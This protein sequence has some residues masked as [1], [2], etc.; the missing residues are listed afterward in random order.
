M[1][2][3]RASATRTAWEHKKERDYNNAVG[4]VHVTSYLRRSKALIWR[5]ISF[6]K[7][8][9]TDH[10]SR[11][12]LLVMFQMRL[13]KY[14]SMS[15]NFKNYPSINGNRAIE[16]TEFFH[17]DM[18]VRILLHH[19]YIRPSSSEP[20]DFINW[21][22]IRTRPKN[23]QSVSRYVNR[24][25]TSRVIAIFRNL[26]AQKLRNRFNK[27]HPTSPNRLARLDQGKKNAQVCQK[28]QSNVRIIS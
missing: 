28:S 20:H 17:P 14:L 3:N 21:T 9:W 27:T 15:S 25:F 2:L 7:V 22:G 8:K 26:T 5:K 10:C 6:W 19:D 4:R 18:Y 23:H 16:S 1:A 13:K 12:C 11:I 24:R